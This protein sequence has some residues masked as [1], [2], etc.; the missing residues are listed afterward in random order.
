[1]LKFAIFISDVGYGHMVRQRC[2]I[3]EIERQFKKPE[4]LIINQSNIE[5]IEQTFKEKYDYLNKFNNIKLFKTKSGFFDLK[6]TN[7]FFDKWMSKK[8]DIFLLE[9]ILKSYDI[10]ISDFVPEAFEIAQKLKIKSFGV[11]HYTW[12]WFFKNSGYK[13]S[14]QIKKL[15]QIELKAH[16]IFIPPLCPDN[17]VDKISKKKF[18]RVN[19]ITEKRKTSVTKNKKPIFLIMD[20]GTKTLSNFISKSLIFME[21]NSKFQFYV[22]AATLNKKDLNFVINSKNIIPIQGLTSIY[23]EIS[24]VDYVIARGGF[25]TITE[26]LINAKPT[27]FADERNNPEIKENLKKIRKNKLGSFITDQDWGKRFNK[28]LDFFHKFEQKKIRNNLNKQRFLFNGANQVVNSIRRE[29][30]DK[31]YS[32]AMSKS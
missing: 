30:N 11:C 27:M 14:N 18:K 12:S 32:R 31:N 8:N 25:N 17:M 10:I 4:I 21:K 2:I 16:K 26:C 22:G 5:I 7:N 29:I 24:K 13:N 3:K 19:F 15:N 9:K 20:N 28:R 6:R 23:S 1:M